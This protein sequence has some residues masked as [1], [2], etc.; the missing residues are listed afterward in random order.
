MT[1]LDQQP[2]LRAFKGRARR[3]YLDRKSA[4][5]F[6]RFAEEGFRQIYGTAAQSD[7]AIAEFEDVQNA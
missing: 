7:G 6:R 2:G 3:R 1:A 5:S 4:A